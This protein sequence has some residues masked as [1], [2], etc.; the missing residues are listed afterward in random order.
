MG[1]IERGKG[2]LAVFSKYD[3]VVL[4]VKRQ[5]DTSKSTTSEEQTVDLLRTKSSISKL[6]IVDFGG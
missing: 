1:K 2:G 3:D 6:E 4:K 5:L